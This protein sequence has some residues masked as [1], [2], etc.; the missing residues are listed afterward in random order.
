MS[1]EAEPQKQRSQVQP[2]NEGKKL[3]LGTRENNNLVPS[4]W[5]GTTSEAE[6][7]LF[8]HRRQSLKSNVPRFNLGTRERS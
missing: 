6:P 4:L 1:Q 3:N 5:L 2:G 8:C 7:P